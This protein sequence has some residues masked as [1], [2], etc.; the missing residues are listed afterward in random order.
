M[1]IEDV[2]GASYGERDSHINPWGFLQVYIKKGKS[3]GV[4]YIYDE[5]TEIL[6]EENSVVGVKTK[7]GD[8]ILSGIIINA[9]KLTRAYSGL[10][11]VNTIDANAIVGEHPELYGFYLATGFS[12]HGLQQAPAIGKGLS[13]LIRLQL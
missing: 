13:E 6:T 4:K 2:T 7:K 5:V 9:L 12:G 3:L 8:K 10:Y 1:N 11:C